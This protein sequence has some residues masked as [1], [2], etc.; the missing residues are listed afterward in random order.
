MEI[1]TNHTIGGQHNDQQYSARFRVPEAEANTP[2][3]KMIRII[4]GQYNEKFR[5]ADGGYINVDGKP[6]QVHYCDETHFR[7]GSTH[8]H[9]CQFGERVIDRGRDVRPH[10]M[11]G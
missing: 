2:E 5:V 8:Y 4:D 10:T 9:I 1:T 6:Y 7:I 11:E 3:T